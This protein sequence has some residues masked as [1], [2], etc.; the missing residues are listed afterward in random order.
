MK[1]LTMVSLTGALAFAAPALAD[2][3]AP[4]TTPSA[5]QQCKT[6]RSAPPAGMGKDAFALTYGTNANKSNAFGK[7][8]SKRSAK[9]EDAA[10]AAKTNSAKECKALEAADAAGFKMTYGTGKNGSNAYGKCVSSKA[11]AKEAKEV[12]TEVK[13][14][15]NAAKSCKAERKANPGS[16]KAKNAFGKCVST[17]AKAKADDRDAQEQEQDSTPATQ[18]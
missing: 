6:Q 4:T 9:T 1:T 12:K 8:V 15:V 7:C 2:D 14:E 10:K 11:K 3:S 17:K 18:S 13:D 16:F 5:S